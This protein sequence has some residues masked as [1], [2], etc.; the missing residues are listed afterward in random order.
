MGHGSALV[1]YTIIDNGTGKNDRYFILTAHHSLY[2][3]WSLML[4]MED[5]D[6]LYHNNKLE[7]PAAPY[8]G[9]IK[10]LKTI[11]PFAAETFWKSTF[12]NRLLRTFPEPRFV[13][14]AEVET[15]LSQSMSISRPAGSEIT[16]STVIR[17]AWALVTARYAETDDVFF[18]ATLMGRNASLP[19]ID[20]LT[21]PTITTVPVCVSI[22]LARTVGQYLHDIQHEATNMMPFEHTGLQNIKRM[23]PEAEAACSFQDL[24]VIQP[25]GSENMSSDMWEDQAL[26]ARG[27]M[28][29]LTYA[30]IVECRL[31]KDKIR[32]T[33]QYRDHIIPTLQMQRI[34]DQFEEVLLQL[35]DASPE[36]ILGCIDICSTKDKKELRAWN[37]CRANI[38]RAEHCI[39]NLIQQQAIHQPRAQAIESWDGSFTYEDLDNL[40]TRLAHHL[41]ALGACP[42]CFIPL[43]FDKSAWTVVAILAVLKVGAAYVSLDPK[44]PQIR[45]DHIIQE[46]SA[47]IILTAPQYQNFFDSKFSIVIIDQAL[48]NRLSG[49]SHAAYSPGLPSNAAFVVFSEFK[50]YNPLIILYSDFPQRPD[51]P[52]LL[53]AL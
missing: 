11:D 35:N 10:H 20:R 40:S 9:F 43:C 33:A 26:F 14:P 17:G 48:A 51:Q 37:E 41:S 53:K 3:G 25:E 44:H 13:T 8:A 52:V 32:I 19:H 5:L 38:T 39:H 45:R 6:H 2:D 22:D 30:L 42:G 15:Q 29:V 18:G 49:L 34:M 4:I 1:R 27:E 36:T 50:R 28:V 21:G 23:G 12:E 31:Y 7:K 46:V 16:L 24:L 47:K